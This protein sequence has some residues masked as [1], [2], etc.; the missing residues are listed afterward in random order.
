MSDDI[1]IQNF[2]T[3]EICDLLLTDDGEIAAIL[4]NAV[5][6]LIYQMAGLDTRPSAA[7]VLNQLK[8]VA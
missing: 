8:T 7:D 3:G 2:T 5:K 1:H 4:G 6:Q